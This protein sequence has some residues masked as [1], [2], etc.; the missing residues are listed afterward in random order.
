MEKELTK[1]QQQENNSSNQVNHAQNNDA[2]NKS[3]DASNQNHSS[4]NENLEQQKHQTHRK[5][6]KKRSNNSNQQVNNANKK[7]QDEA[8]GEQEIFIAENAKTY[9]TSE[10]RNM[11]IEALMSFAASIGV[12]KPETFRKQELVFTVLKKLASEGNKIMGSGVL[13]IFKD[14]RGFLR[15]PQVNYVAGADDVH[16]PAKQI[17]KHKLRVGDLVDGQLKPPSKNEKHFSLFSITA[18]NQMSVSDTKMRAHFEDLT[19]I[20]PTEQ[21]KF[22]NQSD[23]KKSVISSRIIDLV[24][25]LG[26]GQ[27]ALLVAPPRTG[28]TVLMQNI[29]HSIT[30]NYPEVNLIVLLIGERPEEVT[31][32]SRSV[33][34]EV[35]SSTF[36]E[37]SS[38]HVQLA[39]TTIER[40][41]RLVENGKDVVVLLDSIT[42][43]ARAYNDVSPSSGKILS[44]GVD[45]NALQKPKKFFG[46]ARNIENGG[47]L[48]II[49][50]ALTETGSRM[51]EVIF[52]EFK[53]TGNS[54]I[55]LD[56]RI[57]DRRIFPAIDIPRSGTR[58]EDLLVSREKLAKIRILRRITNDMMSHESLEFFIEKL[59]ATTSNDMFFKVMDSLSGSK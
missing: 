46:A 31:D 37:P 10:M 14:G 51:D 16:I 6:P 53:G 18:I 41:K 38:R 59:A 1:S 57:S 29:A 24:A 5:V 27:R 26:K 8:N 49:A 30:D 9:H 43:L 12:A 2:T 52:E 54:E 58:K 40:A 34:G 36:D 7:K 21:I 33:K 3:G 35:V 17:S 11:R 45:S 42:R 39:E 48:T 56:R 50:T 13:E 47:S 19:P 23:A 28:K 25:P 22:E 32:M 15:S 4:K 55:L 20:F 44:G